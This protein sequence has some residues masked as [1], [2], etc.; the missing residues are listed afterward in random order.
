MIHAHN[1]QAEE[2]QMFHR[3]ARLNPFSGRNVMNSA[4]NQMSDS[5]VNQM[6]FD[7]PEDLG[8]VASRY[9]PMLFHVA[10]RR[11]RNKEDAEDAVQDAL[12]SAC[13]H[14]GQFEGRS[15]LSS[16]LT[17]IV[18]NTAGMKLR[19]R[20]RREVVSLDQDP[21]DGGLAIANEL[22]DAGP[23][24]ENICAQTEMREKIRGAMAELS[25]KLRMAFQMHEV[26]GLSTREA[27]GALGITTN[28]LKSRVSR[29]RRTIGACLVEN[30]GGKRPAEE[31]KA[32]AASDS[33]SQPRQRWNLRRPRARFV[34]GGR[35]FAVRSVSPQRRGLSRSS[36]GQV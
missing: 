19:K 29:A 25:P 22:A 28:T 2:Q 20:A 8:S 33:A 10:F 11:L 5:T 26:A 16:W 30:A 6:F 27:A 21:E 13:K 3:A 4:A 31:T 34:S 7:Q 18:I 14:I 1:S 35:R 24:P 12:L 17:R 23:N 32:A 9:S 15:Q 36:G